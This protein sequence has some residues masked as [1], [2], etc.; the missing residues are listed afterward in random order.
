[1]VDDGSSPSGDDGPTDWRTAARLGAWLVLPQLALRKARRY[2]DRILQARIA[3]LSFVVLHVVLGV[4]LGLLVASAEGEG[5]V[6]ATVAIG[7]VAIVGLGSILVR[8]RTAERPL[9][10]DE[11][12]S[13]YDDWYVRYLRELPIASVT[14]PWAA[15]AGVYGRSPL[16][17]GLGVALAAVGLY[18]AMPSDARLDRDAAAVRR[19]HPD[20]D[21]L[22]VLRSGG[23]DGGGRRGGGRSTDDGGP[24]GP[25]P[26]RRTG[27]GDDR[28]KSKKRD[29][30]R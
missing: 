17:W 9:E 1:M 12:G 14:L 10:P 20:V 21:L 24:S 19:D 5:A 15:V 16:A 27:G 13:L 8:R 23:D 28:A 29:R 4:V 30:R 26:T 18:L 6:S 2:P 11:P 7:S 22:A 3:W 25:A